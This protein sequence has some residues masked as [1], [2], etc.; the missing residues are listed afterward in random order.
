MQRDRVVFHPCKARLVG[1]IS[2]GYYTHYKSQLDC[3]L[4]RQQLRQKKPFLHFF[5]VYTRQ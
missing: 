4:S 3:Y 1:P 2:G 5:F